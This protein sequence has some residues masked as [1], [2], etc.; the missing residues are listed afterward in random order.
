MIVASDPP[1]IYIKGLDLDNYDDLRIIRKL[2]E[3][4]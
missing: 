1:K 4:L 3:K 2:L